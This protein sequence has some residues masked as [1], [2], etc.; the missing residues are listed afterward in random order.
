MSKHIIDDA[1][2]CLQC[3]NPLCSAGCPIGTPIR[4]VISLLL[5]NRLE[6]AGR[7]L[8]ENNPLSLV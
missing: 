8:F 5:D 2:R 7:M 4:E 6:E 3:N 1:K